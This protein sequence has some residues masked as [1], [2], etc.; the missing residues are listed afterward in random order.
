MSVS[1]NCVTLSGRL[2]K[3]PEVRYTKDA[4]AIARFSLAV[5]NGKD[6]KG[7]DRPAYFPNIVCFGKLAE[8]VERW[9]F[10]G[11][12][13]IIQGKLSTGS[14]MNEKDSR[15][16]YVTEVIASQVLFTDRIQAKEEPP[17]EPPKD[18]QSNIPE[19]FTKVND[20]DIPF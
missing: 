14:Y 11:Q 20:D 10:K 4:R 18:D 6:D 12:H 3:D 2:T 17:Q 5:N 16:V 15:R 19:G 7:N 9:A 13:V 8:T 1:I